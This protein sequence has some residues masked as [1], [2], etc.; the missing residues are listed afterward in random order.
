MVFLIIIYGDFPLY[1]LQ[2][3]NTR[4]SSP[5]VATLRCPGARQYFPLNTRESESQF[6]RDSPGGRCAL[7]TVITQLVVRDTL[8]MTQSLKEQEEGLAHQGPRKE[9]PLFSAKV[10]PAGKTALFTRESRPSGASPDQQS[11]LS[12]SIEYRTTTGRARRGRFVCRPEFSRQL[13]P[14]SSTWPGTST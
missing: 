13:F 8:C 12:I 14:P 6:S 3:T 9:S 11:S 10:I 2:V 1:E 4:H 5:G 7:R